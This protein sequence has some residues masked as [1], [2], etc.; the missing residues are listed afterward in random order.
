VSVCVAVT[1]TPGSTALLSSR[2]VPLNW[3][4]ACAQAALAVSRR[5]NAPREQQ[6]VHVFICVN[7]STECS[8]Y[9]L[10]IPLRSVKGGP[11]I[12]AGMVI[13]QVPFTRAGV[14]VCAN[15]RGRSPHTHAG[16]LA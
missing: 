13:H 4:V 16:S 14:Y 7:S 1:L 10:G 11:G 12:W 5:I 3:A 15:L 8:R 9:P 2:T 6:L